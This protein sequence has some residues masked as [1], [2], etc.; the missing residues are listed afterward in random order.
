MDIA[1]SPES[2]VRQAQSWLRG[3]RGKDVVFTSSFYKYQSRPEPPLKRRCIPSR[4]AHQSWSTTAEASCSLDG[5]ISDLA[6]DVVPIDRTP[7][8][9]TES[10]CQEVVVRNVAPPSAT[11][12]SFTTAS[13]EGG[14]STAN[15]TRQLKKELILIHVALLMFL[16]A[17]T[18]LVVIF[19]PNTLQ[20]TSTY[21][22]PK[23]SPRVEPKFKR[24]PPSAL[25]P[26]PT[27]LPK[28]V[29]PQAAPQYP[30][31]AVDVP[32]DVCTTEP[33][34]RDGAYINAL[35]IRDVDPCDDF[36]K[37]VCGRW[38]SQNSD[39]T[40][41]QDED[42][43]YNL[44]I[45][46]RKLLESPLPPSIRDSDI[47]L[48][49]KHV[50][51]ICREAS[52]AFHAEDF[53]ELLSAADLYGFPFT[54][55]VRSSLSVWK[56]AARALLLTGASTLLSVG[57]TVHPFEPERDVVMVGIPEPLLPPEV[58]TTI[59]YR[60]VVQASMNSLGKR[61]VPSVYAT[62]VVE[63]AR[64]LDKMISS[65][66]HLRDGERVRRL[67][68]LRDVPEVQV[69][70]M[71]IIDGQRLLDERQDI[72][73]QSPGFLN[74]LV[75]FV[76][77]SDAHVILNFLSVHVI[78]RASAYS[79][80]TDPDLTWVAESQLFDR[81]IHEVPRW[82]F[83]IRTAA[84]TLPNLFLYTSHLVV[85]HTTES[86][87]S[88]LRDALLQLSSRVDVLTF[89]D[90]KTRALTQQIL[91]EV[92]F[93][94]G[95]PPWLSDNHKLSA[96]TAIMPRVSTKEKFLRWVSNVS[97]AV[98]SAALRRPSNN[99]WS[100]SPLG[101]DCWHDLQVKTV[102]IPVLL[103]NWSLPRVDDSSTFQLPRTGHRVVRCLVR[104]LVEGVSS[105]FNREI[106]TR[107]FWSLA[108]KSSLHQ[109]QLCL[110]EQMNIP[111]WMTLPLL[112]DSSALIVIQDMFK[113][114]TRG[115]SSFAFRDVRLY[116]AEDFS[117]DHL[118]YVYYALGY[119]KSR[120]RDK[121]TEEQ[122]L[123]V[124]VP[125]RGSPAFQSAFG[126]RATS[127]MGPL[128]KCD[129]PVTS[130]GKHSPVS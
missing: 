125:L 82:R 63:F 95:G 115:R 101:I 71:E 5:G 105:L 57:V 32:Y 99:S 18:A 92:K 72:L 112:E 84:R 29:P 127:G 110:Q 126:C 65:S 93:V 44:E 96:Y 80:T 86:L 53:L 116:G 1:R 14:A 7:S 118:F 25:P 19:Y 15:R 62:Q 91:T 74:N 89:L 117:S 83:C 60:R 48:P 94:I 73:L 100:G 121:K 109:A 122:A 20:R 90:D 8:S 13:M 49:L 10:I 36:Y 17:A 45:G 56:A 3:H 79:T 69:Y 11:G 61:F 30:V 81:P 21:R 87:K 54:P 51:N 26:R 38:K 120:L 75:D 35:L 43:V 111:A 12:N 22:G 47:L 31:A 102:Y 76:R 37:Y 4:T 33:C 128:D 66:D 46:I 50:F 39:V 55:P 113:S 130:S 34:R 52:N 67:S 98:Q 77:R 64:E 27:S 59:A 42:L 88:L 129:A 16:C 2:S 23:P 78:V 28:P 108:A 119:C 58:R 9:A 24:A 123:G 106:V 41:S 6:N 97:K 124:N 68:K 40:T 85:R 107:S 70:L 104:M 103:S 114:N